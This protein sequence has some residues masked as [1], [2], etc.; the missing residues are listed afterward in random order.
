M[1]P[2]V[3]FFSF[4]FNLFLVCLPRCLG[5]SHDWNFRS[6]FFFYVAQLI[7]RLRFELPQLK[8]A[9][10]INGNK[11]SMANRFSKRNHTNEIYNV[12]LA[13]LHVRRAI[14]NKWHC[15]EWQGQQSTKSGGRFHRGNWP[16][17]CCGIKPKKLSPIGLC[18]CINYK[19]Y[20]QLKIV[21]FIHS[22]YRRVRRRRHR[23]SMLVVAYSCIFIYIC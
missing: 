3:F 20:N 19:I 6:I 17:E 16:H 14:I 15:I 21:S 7:V 23:R 8:M 12:A 1:S 11:Q 9:I 18:V 13:P 5:Q 10:R 22:K 2:S 4:Q